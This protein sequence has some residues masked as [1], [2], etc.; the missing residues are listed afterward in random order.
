ML[1]SWVVIFLVV[2]LIAGFFGFGGVASDSAWIAKVL[3]FIFLVLFL[4]AW[5]QDMGYLG[6]D[7]KLF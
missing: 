6:S 3:F 2:A 4:I 1:L 7:M 5:M